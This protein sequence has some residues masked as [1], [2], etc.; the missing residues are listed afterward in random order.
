MSKITSLLAEKI[1]PVVEESGYELVDVEYKKEGKNWYLR[2]FIDKANGITLDDCQIVSRRL[3]E[4]LD[5]WDII[6]NAYF[7]EVSSPGLERPLKKPTDYQRFT[8]KKVKIKT[9]ETISDRKNFVG[10][11]MGIDDGVV[12]IQVE[13]QEKHIPFN[14]ISSAKL[15]F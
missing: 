12:I 5:E 2:I 6:P 7:L 3:D 14:K 13:G 8:G 1:T 10:E 9:N 11:I 15:V 4:L